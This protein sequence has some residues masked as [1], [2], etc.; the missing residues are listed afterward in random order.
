MDNKVTISP[1]QFQEGLR[2]M[3][4]ASGKWSQGNTW[5]GDEPPTED[6]YA[7]WVDTSQEDDRL[8]FK[9]STGAWKTISAGGSIGGGGSGGVAIEPI[10]DDEQTVAPGDQCSI[11]FNWSTL[12]SQTARGTITAYVNSTQYYTKT[13]EQGEVIIPLEGCL[14]S[15]Q[16]NEVKIVVKDIYGSTNEHIFKVSVIAITISSSFRQNTRLEK[17][18]Y[19]DFYAMPFIVKGSLD[20]TVYAILDGKEDPVA[21]I[22]V[23]ASDAGTQ[24]YIKIPSCSHGSHT[25]K[26]YAEATLNQKTIKSNEIYYD[27]LWTEEGNYNT[28]IVSP[29]NLEKADQYEILEIPYYIYNPKSNKTEVYFETNGVLENDI[30]KEVDQKEYIWET[31]GTIADEDKEKY[32][33]NEFI[34]RTADGVEKRFVVKIKKVDTVDVLPVTSA[35]PLCLIAD[36]T[37][38]NTDASR[39]IWDST[40]DVKNINTVFNNF[41]WKTNGW[42]TVNNKGALRISDGA[43]IQIPYNIFEGAVISGYN[44][45]IRTS[46]CTIEVDLDFDDVTN[47]DI[48][49]LSCMSEGR[50]IEITPTQALVQSSGMS[51]K[52]LFSE[53]ENRGNSMRFSFVITP[54]DPGV[55]YI[56]I[57]GIGA[58]SGTYSTNDRFKHDKEPKGITI[59][60]EGCSVTL[61]S[62]R[63]YCAALTHREIIRNWIYDMASVAEQVNA[64]KR[65]D[66]YDTTTTAGNVVLYSKVVEQIPCMVITGKMPTYKGDKKIVDIEF[67]GT[68]NQLYD[69]ILRNAQIDVQGTSSQYYPYKNWK[70]KSS[71]KLTDDMGNVISKPKMKFE[72]KDGSFE[73]YALDDNQIPSNVF[74]LKADYM[75]SSSTHNTVTANIANNMYSEKTP[76]QRKDTTGRTRTTIFGRPIVIFYKDPDTG[77]LTFGG[78]YNFNYDKDSEAVFGFTEDSDYEVVE[79]VEFCNN[80][81]NRCRLK[82]SEYIKKKPAPAGYDGD[83]MDANGDIPEYLEDFEFRYQWRRE[84][85]N[86]IK[87]DY[88]KAATDWVVSTDRSKATGDQLPSPYTTN[89]GIAVYLYDEDMNIVTFIDGNG[90]TR[91]AIDIGLGD[92]EYAYEAH[93]EEIEET[94]D[95]GTITTKVVTYYALPIDDNGLE[96]YSFT[97]DTEAY[98]L[99]KFKNELSEHFNV[100]YSL[101][102]YHLIDLLGMIDSGTKNC[103]WATWGERHAK[104]S[105]PT[106]DKVVIWYPIFYDMDTML[107]LS[108]MG[109]MD[110]P[111]NA[112]FDSLMP[113]STSSYVYNG[114]DNVFWNNI[115]DGFV[116]ELNTL[117]RS[118]VSDGTFAQQSMLGS[119][120]E[121]SENFSESLYNE[122][123]NLKLLSPF[124]DG[125]F[126]YSE[127]S[128]SEM[129]MQHPNYVY[130]YQGDRFYHRRYW[131]PNRYNYVCSKNMAGSYVTDYITMRLN[132]PTGEL[133]VPAESDFTVTTYADQ[134][135]RI[136]Y[137]SK[138]VF[139][140]CIHNKPTKIIAPPDTFNDTETIIYGASRLMSIGS[141]AG[142]Y[143]RSIDISKA[144]RLTVADIGS[145]VEGYSNE[146]LDEVYF[147]SNPMIQEVYLQ[148]C[149]KLE[150]TLSLS[151]CPR[152]KKIKANGTKISLLEVPSPGSLE[153]VIL[154]N[155]M[156]ALNLV[157]HP[158]LNEFTLEHVIKMDENGEEYYEYNLESIRVEETPIDT[159]DLVEHSPGLSRLR[160]SGINWS[161]EDDNLLHRI[162]NDIYG[163]DSEGKDQSLPV[164]MGDCTVMNMKD[165]IEKDFHSFFNNGVLYEKLPEMSKRDFRLNVVN[166]IRTHVVRFFNQPRPEDTP[167]QMYSGILDDR[168]VTNTTAAYK[169]ETP[170]KTEDWNKTYQFDKWG[171]YVNGELVPVDN[172]GSYYITQDTDFYAIYEETKKEFT[173][174]YY[175][176]DIQTGSYSEHRTDVFTYD[177]ISNADTLNDKILDEKYVMLFKGW[178]S[179]PNDTEPEIYGNSIIAVTESSPYFQ[180]YYA[181]YQQDYRPYTIRFLD[182][183]GA[184]IEEK[185]VKYSYTP[186]APQDPERS[187]TAEFD[188]TFNKWVPDMIPV[189]GNADYV[190]DYSRETREY[191]VKWIDGDNNVIYSE[192]V[193]YGVIPEYNFEKYGVPTKQGDAQYSYTYLGWNIDIIPVTGEIDYVATFTPSVNKYTVKWLNYNGEV[194]IETDTDVEYGQ[195]PKYDGDIPEKPGNAEFSYDFLG[196]DS[197]VTIEVENHQGS[198]FDPV[199]CDVVYT[200]VYYERK[201][202]YDVTFINYDGTT[203]KSDKLE[204][205]SAIIK[206][207]DPTRTGYIFIGWSPD[208]ATMVTGEAT[209]TAQYSIIVSGAEISSRFTKAGYYSSYG[210]PN[211]FIAG[212]GNFAAAYNSG[213]AAIVYGLNFETLRNV[214]NLN[215][216]GLKIE[217]TF[218]GKN[219]IASSLGAKLGY[220]FVASAGTSDKTFTDIGDGT[221]TFAKG[222][223]TKNFCITEA[224][225]PNTFAWIKNNIQSFLNGYTSN[226]FGAYLNLSMGCSVTPITVTLICDYNE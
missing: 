111:Y 65:N 48:P 50:G 174:K 13:H 171:V 16:T 133:A 29:F 102:Y 15:G 143:A 216:T 168:V 8:L 85:T 197:N 12:N 63:V 166:S 77:V 96:V 86:N 142:K 194:V 212:T 2:R 91:R 1:S 115:K 59:S 42:R 153:E 173:V 201:N 66:I 162:K 158:N 44:T 136:K 179:S 26:L 103:F 213:A 11:I 225:I 28:I 163:L 35:M 221:I 31:S 81:S 76:P 135:T 118:K 98:R 217:G 218:T 147:G 90:R 101:M 170:I 139:S 183:N 33:N 7:M 73:S 145:D 122:D 137:G 156:T 127:D 164:L 47:V 192:E 152:I 134:Y 38:S 214:K 21:T 68:K 105:D 94:D 108:N 52:T 27:L 223:G 57:N 123:G 93:D 169:G 60:S 200:P 144:K 188:Y 10:S 182:W 45:D 202:V 222:D 58:A 23:S 95:D 180:E 210:D 64:H 131:F 40:G 206:P 34:I 87:Y 3:M 187:D 211:A 159:K 167:I 67:T 75:E 119:Y 124:I 177:Q 46:G 79:C 37:H 112:E 20:K 157:E 215:I 17:E 154:P 92:L 175:D 55:V 151:E 199:R 150:G 205:G 129:V 74:C 209:Y 161:L 104:H 53:G 189:T 203:I 121:H 84:E 6:Q 51:V 196:W 141:L 89:V 116:T 149:S 62:V 78:K 56:Y 100:H 72:M 4:E 54:E 14:V 204:Y 71:Y 99:T 181:I 190:A 191:L 43:S 184:L 176:I 224:N 128:P 114:H 178:S 219:S 132:T 125:Y 70:F 106:K 49:F 69:F 109:K 220:G 5:I 19:P 185:S 193:K 120:E 208:V 82:T 148:N 130:I 22:N 36:K 226:S 88:L 32:V 138:T 110:I 140:R 9:T 172:L 160:L 126:G 186:E 195:L 117:F 207:S 80:T 165:Y 97:H 113:G 198:E 24:Q 155:T 18:K 25:L 61:H 107:G 83:D 30:A 39:E 41:N 146:N